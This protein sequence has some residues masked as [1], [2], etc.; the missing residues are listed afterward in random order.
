M[1]LLRRLRT[2]EA[3][4]PAFRG[5]RRIAKMATLLASPSS[6]RR[7][8]AGYWKAAKQQLKLESGGKRAYCEAPA[9]AVAHGD[10]EHFRPKTVYWWLAYCYDNYVYA[11]QICNQVSKGDAFPTRAARMPE[12]V[13]ADGATDE[14][15]VRFIRCL[16]PD[17]LNEPDG[18]A[19]AEFECAMLAEQAELLNPYHDVPE[20]HFA[21]RADPVLKEVVLCAK[22]GSAESA[23]IVA[24]AEKYY[25]LNREELKRW[26]WRTYEMIETLARVLDDP[27]IDAPLQKRVRAQIHS[28]LSHEGEFA[29]MA[30][31]FPHT[32]WRLD[33]PAWDDPA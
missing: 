25:G 20:T 21:W 26:R 24:A 15:R 10:V 9:A 5:E 30:R 29:G 32:Q 6:E 13:V 11:C 23:R 8:D 1:I 17:P 19:W 16:A 22:D 4:P 12:P 3:I 2:S 31:Y 27:R 28:M 7:F 33:L 14:E 18:L